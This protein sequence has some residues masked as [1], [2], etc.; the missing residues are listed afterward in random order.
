MDTMPLLK[1]EIGKEYEISSI[2]TND[3]DLESFLFTLGCYKGEFITIVSLVS[4]TYTIALKDARYN[5]DRDL[6]DAIKVV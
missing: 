6:A 1:A 4:G 5:I 3:K 2:D